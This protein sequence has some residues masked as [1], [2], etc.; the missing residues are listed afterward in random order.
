MNELI[1]IAHTIAIGT[2]ILV[3]L[4]LGKS[5][6]ITLMSMLC[7][8]ANLFVIKQIT[9]CTLFATSADA[10]IIGIS[11]CLNMLQEYY[12]KAAARQAIIISFV[13]AVIATILSQFQLWYCPA[14][15]DTAH[16]HFIPLLQLM[17]RIIIASLTTYAIVQTLEYYLYG[18][19]QKKMPDHLVARNYLS[20]ATTQGID[21]VLFSFLGLYGIVE[22]IGHII[23]IS[24]SIKIAALV[25]SSP[26]LWL[27][28]KIVK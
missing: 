26:F 11:L 28:K 19:L 14:I 6:L 18:F 13:M 16:A 25:V 27:S 15:H 7:V 10:L 8:L 3:A 12:G 24:Y 9:L 4:K 17:P 23:I 20:I 22:N 1:F 5:A 2:S 21:T